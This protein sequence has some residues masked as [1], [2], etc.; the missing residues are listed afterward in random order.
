LIIAKAIVRRYPGASSAI[1]RCRGHPA[2]RSRPLR[3]GP[4]RARLGASPAPESPAT[5]CESGAARAV[6]W[7]ALVHMWAPPFTLICWPVT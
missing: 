6:H 4:A 7:L 5:A 2:A 3:G 1:A